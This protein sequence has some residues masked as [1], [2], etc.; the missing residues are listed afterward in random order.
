[1]FKFQS[2]KL[3]AL[4]SLS[5]NTRW[6]HAYGDGGCERPDGKWKAYPKRWLYKNVYVIGRDREIRVGVFVGL[7]LEYIAKFV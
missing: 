7:N 4:L 6:L 2:T 5:F 3:A 1:M